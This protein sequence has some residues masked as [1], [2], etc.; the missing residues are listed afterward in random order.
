MSKS[1]NDRHN[2]SH[3]SNSNSGCSKTDNSPTHN[4]KNTYAI[5]IVVA[6]SNCTN[7]GPSEE[8]LGFTLGFR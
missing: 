7:D 3:S 2:G 1:L 8:G 4:A 6:Y 5:E